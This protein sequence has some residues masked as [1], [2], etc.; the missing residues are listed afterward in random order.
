MSRQSVMILGVVASVLFAGVAAAAPPSMTRDDLICRGQSGV[1]FSYWWGNGAWCTNGCSP[2]LSSCSPGVCTPNPGSSG[3]PNCSHSGSKGA[4]CSGFVAKVWAVP[5]E[6]AFTTNK[7]P[8]STY[9]FYWNSTHWDHIDKGAADKGDSLVYRKLTTGGSDCSSS[10][11][12]SSGGHIVL[13]KSGDPWGYSYVYHAKGCNYGIKYENKSISSKY[14]AR[15][16]DNLSTACIPSTEICNGADDD[17]DGAIDENGVCEADDE[18]DFAASLRQADAFTDVDGDGKADVC[19]RAAAGFRCKL[20]TG[21]G[22]GAQVEGGD[23]TNPYFDNA[24]GWGARARYATLR[25]GDLNGDGKADICGRSGAA[26]YCFRSNG[27]VFTSGSSTPTDLSDGAGWTAEKYYSTI[28]LAD[29]TGDGKDDLCVRYASGWGCR[30]ST[31]TGF[32]GVIGGP[33]ISD[34]SGWGHPEHYGTIRMGD[35][36]GDGK[37]DLCARGNA[38]VFCWKSTGSGFGVQVTGPALSDAMGF[39]DV[40]YWSTIR[41]AD[42]N[43]DGKADLCTR[44]STDFRCYLSNG[45]GFGGAVTKAIMSD[46]SGWGD[47]DNYSTIRLGDI[48]ADGD[49]DLCA[50]ANAN[51]VCWKWTGGGFGG[52]I[53]G[54]ALSDGADWDAPSHYR[55]IRLADVTGDGKADICGRGPAGVRCYPSTGNGFGGVIN[56]PGWS[57]AQGFDGDSYYSTFRLG[58]PRVVPCQPTGEVCNGVDDDCDGQVDEGLGN[59]SCGQ[60]VCVHT[61]PVCVG[62]VPQACDTMQGSSAEACNGLDDDCDG[63]VDEAL[64][65]TTCGQGICN[66]QQKN[67]VGGQV[68]TCDPYQGAAVET[69]NGLDDDCDGVADEGFGA[70]TCGVGV[71]YHEQSNCAGGEIAACDPMEGATPEQCNGL[72]DDCDGE[73]DETA[74]CD[75]GL[76]CTAETCVDGTCVPVASGIGC[77]LGGLCVDA[78]APNPA[79]P[80]LACDPGSPLDWTPS[81]AGVPCEDGAVCTIDDQC[82]DG[83]CV[84]GPQDPCDAISTDCITGV[85]DEE[86]GGCVPSVHEDGTQCDDEGDSCTTDLCLDGACVHTVK[87][88]WEPCE[89]DTFSCTKGY[90]LGGNCAQIIVGGCLVDGTCYEQDEP[91]LDVQCRVCDMANSMIAWSLAAD[92]AS[93][94]DGRVCSVKDTCMGGLCVTGTPRDCASLGGPCVTGRCDEEAGGCVLTVLPEGTPCGRDAYCENG[95]QFL[96]PTCDDEGGCGNPPRVPCDPYVG[97]A[98][99]DFCATTCV[100]DEDCIEGYTCRGGECL[101]EAG[102]D[103]GVGPEAGG[104][105]GWSGADTAAPGEEIV[106]VPDGSVALESSSSGGCS[107]GP[108][109]GGANGSWLLLLL[110]VLL[111]GSRRSSSAERP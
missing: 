38:G 34:A 57:D 58:G 28:R 69:C 95:W 80:C 36:D 108:V 47:I 71:C 48:D 50:R 106:D 16:R 32:G 98:D 35:I 53:N 27:S 30:A 18:V 105:A 12:C 96:P 73:V 13:Y 55:S 42:V 46:A 29:I 68:Q 4:D 77:W 45:N 23:P 88:D 64:A 61:Q 87:E 111:V 8:Y 107:A 43:G 1:G 21:S 20:A 102:G 99:G 41:L 90:C 81:P 60:G 110:M 26:F 59:Q 22:F 25:M 101:E 109:G 56:G 40:R 67:C 19:I 72:D 103:A 82:L 66:H 92:G 11:S 54:P 94:D 52:Q 97:C 15:R 85:C 24:D 31:G 39:D 84:G 65:K 33:T 37:Q 44:T 6:Y 10:S 14:K 75:D 78:G 51:M 7:H 3:C 104:D 86:V 70:V 93:C 79:D 62:G 63:Q 76:S 100:D 5:I 49:L 89:A 91:A 83:I 74:T 2:N 17:C 9:H